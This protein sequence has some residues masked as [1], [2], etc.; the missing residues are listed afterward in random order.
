MGEG[1]KQGPRAFHCCWKGS[2]DVIKGMDDSSWHSAQLEGSAAYSSGRQKGEHSR[3]KHVP[4]CGNLKGS[5]ERQ[6]RRQRGRACALWLLL[7]RE[8]G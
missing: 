3:E 4:F 6:S 2:S 7:D 1:T 5:C 8:C